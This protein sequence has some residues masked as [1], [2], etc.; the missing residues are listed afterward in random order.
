[1]QWRSTMNDVSE[2]VHHSASTALVPTTIPNGAGL[3]VSVADVMSGSA[4]ISWASWP[5]R[6][7]ADRLAV[8][9]AKAREAAPVDNWIGKPFRL[10]GVVAHYCMVE[11]DE[12]EV[13]QCV[14]C[15]LIQ[16]DGSTV[17]AVSGGIV[18][19]VRE[20]VETMGEGPWPDGI[21][22][23]IRQVQ[24]RRKRRTYKIEVD[25]AFIADLARQ[26]FTGSADRAKPKA[27]SS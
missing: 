12:G 2:S 26:A 18:D 13:Q 11:S 8:Y 15:I 3:P 16:S 7:M 27:K 24:T 5:I 21:P 9:N 17:A 19:S 20:L 4:A 22:V 25:P 10:S 6:S 23:T 1:M 14:R